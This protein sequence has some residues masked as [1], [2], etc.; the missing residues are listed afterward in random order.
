MGL[1][2][3][4]RGDKITTFSYLEDPQRD[5]LGDQVLQCDSSSFLE[6]VSK[7]FDLRQFKTFNFFWMKMVTYRRYRDV[8]IYDLGIDR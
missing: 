7:V 1:A 5:R 2:F 4:Y 6:A 3:I 8:D